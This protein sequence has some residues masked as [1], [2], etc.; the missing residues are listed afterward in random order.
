[1]RSK[2][3]EDLRNVDD[4]EIPKSLLGLIQIYSDN[5]AASLKCS[6]SVEYPFHVVR[7]NLNAKQGMNLVDYRHSFLEF[8]PA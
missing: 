5:R 3:A 8:H 2:K 1:M 7:L 6:A 4:S